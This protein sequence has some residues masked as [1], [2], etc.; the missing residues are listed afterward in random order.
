MLAMF[1]DFHAG[2]L[3]ISILNYGIVTLVPKVLGAEQIQKFGLVCLLNVSFKKFTKVLMNK[4]ERV[5]GKGFITYQTSFVKGM[6]LLDGV[7]V[8]REALNSIH[9]E[10][11]YAIIFN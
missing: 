1:N 8:L 5:A 2:K 9:I 4:I 11:K 7:M 10:R 3:D 6:F